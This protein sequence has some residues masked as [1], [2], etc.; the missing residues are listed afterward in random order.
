MKTLTVPSAALNRSGRLD[1]WYFNSPANLAAELLAV[2]RDRG[3]R[4]E[5]LGGL[6][7]LAVAVVHPPRTKRYLAAP[8]EP[9]LPYLR[10]YDVFGYL[11]EAADY[12]SQKRTQT[13][14]YQIGEGTILQTRS[15]RNL[16]PAVVGDKYLSRFV[17][18]D[19]MIRITIDDERMRYYVLTYLKSSTGQAMLRRSKTGSVIDHLSDKQVAAQEVPIFGNGV[20]QEVVAKMSKAVRLREEA[21]LALAE[22][23][24]QYEATLPKITRKRP[25]KEGWSIRSTS[26]AGR[27]DAAF[28]D[29]LVGQIK[30]KLVSLGGVPVKDV[31]DVVMLG[32]Y[33]R[34]YTVPPFGWPI[35]SG[36]QLLQSKPIH[37]Q[38]I[39]PQSFNRVEDFELK[40]GSI[41]YPSDGRAEEGLGTPVIVTADRKGWLAS[42]M[43]GRIYPKK[44]TDLGWLYL[45]LRS[46][47]AQMQFKATASGSV[48]DH[49]YPENMESVILPPPL[50]VDGT[51]AKAAWDK[52]SRAQVTEDEA[53]GVMNAEIADPHPS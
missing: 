31:A 17:L 27:I 21:R 11:P 19:D 25:T 4:F 10:P 50:D 48:V 52:L 8:G 30:K 16:G 36:A 44:G 3:V 13:G 14:I 29:P 33:K 45:A 32:R 12:V 9:S 23:I 51:R 43:V 49:T 46:R 5:R 18:S 39:L 26:F 37:P 41:A 53:V 20:F 34:L 28:Y 7:G 1:S 35:I 6:G 42:N 2:A 24:E 38:Q 22:L 15:G 40:P 47:H